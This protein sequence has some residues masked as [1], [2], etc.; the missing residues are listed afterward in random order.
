MNWQWSSNFISSAGFAPNVSASDFHAWF[1]VYW[2]S[3]KFGS[4]LERRTKGSR[5]P[6]V[7]EPL[8]NPFDNLLFHGHFFAALKY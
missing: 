4:A 7:R 5:S 6:L 3:T 8:K 1:L 2:A